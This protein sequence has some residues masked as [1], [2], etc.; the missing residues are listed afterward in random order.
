[1]KSVWILF[2]LQVEIAKFQAFN[3]DEY[4][5]EASES[6]LLWYVVVKL[7]RFAH[8]SNLE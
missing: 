8:V 1:M 3:F 7:S 5:I 4:T 2:E 6:K